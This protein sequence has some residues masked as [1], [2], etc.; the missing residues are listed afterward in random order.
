MGSNVTIANTK[1]KNN[2]VITDING[3]RGI[4]VTN[5]TSLTLSSLVFS[6][7]V[8]N[9][10][11]AS[12][13]AL[14]ANSILMQQC[15]ISHNFLRPPFP[16][17]PHIM[18]FISIDL[19]KSVSVVDTVI[20]NN[21][22]SVEYE[23]RYQSILTVSAVNRIPG[24]YIQLKNCSFRKNEMIHTHIE[25]ISDIF[26]YQSSFFVP[27]RNDIEVGDIYMIGLKI[28]RL[29]DCVFYD[30]RKMP[31]FYFKYDFSQLKKKRH[32]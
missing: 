3:P 12:L 14:S 32:F 8:I 22:I 9:G 4:L 11:V 13:M 30:Q 21:H 6:S 25:A 19:S 23:A 7:N 10:N 17:L 18:L 27:K 24:S 28:L 16:S 29:W 15:V 20:H 26:I 31:Q 2:S 5:G 1:F